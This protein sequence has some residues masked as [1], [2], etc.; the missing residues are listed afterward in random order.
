MDKT[1]KFN[2]LTAEELFAFAQ[3]EDFAKLG[4]NNSVADEVPEFDAESVYAMDFEL[5][6]QE[7]TEQATYVAQHGIR[8]ERRRR[9]R[10]KNASTKKVFRRI[11]GAFPGALANPEIQKIIQKTSDKSLSNHHA[12]MNWWKGDWERA[13]NAEMRRENIE[14]NKT[15]LGIVDSEEAV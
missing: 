2:E 13:R 3:P 15:Y 1:K 7:E 14:I 8:A 5:L 4:I 12:E 10:N 9:T 6:K 11:Y